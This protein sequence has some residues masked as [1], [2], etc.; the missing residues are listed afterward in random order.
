VERGEPWPEHNYGSDDEAN[1]VIF[2]EHQG[3]S[4]EAVQNMIEETYAR[5]DAYL[6]RTSEATLLSVPE[7]QGDGQDSPI[8]RGIA[9]SYIMHP[10]I[11]LWEYLRQHGY[12]A[13]V[14]VL[15]GDAYTD[16]LL[17]LD[18]SDGW[19]GGVYYN[20]ACLQALSGMKETAIETLGEALRLQPRLI[21]W[22][23]QDSDLASLRDDPAYQALYD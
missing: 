7:G 22:S 4:W 15:F 17:A 1:L 2:N 6:D 20:Q 12:G 3:L 16:R 13:D 18:D 21:E 19:R 5:I 9:G 23:R 14:L 8:W 11:H 10:A